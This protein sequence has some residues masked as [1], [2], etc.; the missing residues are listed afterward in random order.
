MIANT[1]DCGWIDL[2]TGKNMWG[3]GMEMWTMRDGKVAVWEGT[4]NFNEEGKRD[5]GIV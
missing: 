5:T 1:W 4:L 2:Q 3:W